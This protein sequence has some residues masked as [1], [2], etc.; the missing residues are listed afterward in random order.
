M[1][2]RGGKQATGLF[3]ESLTNPHIILLIL[4]RHLLG[5][6][7]PAR[8]RLRLRSLLLL[9]LLLHL[10][11][12]RRDTTARPPMMAQLAPPLQTQ[13]PGT[14]TS[15]TTLKEILAPPGT[16]AG[17]ARVRAGD[18]GARAARA[19]VH[20]VVDDVVVEP[21]RTGRG[22]GVADQGAEDGDR[23]RHDGDCALG[24]GEDDELGGRLGEV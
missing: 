13:Q 20:R 9:L 17:H 5:S 24:A 19:G 6:Q 4:N 3:L 11:R 8:R 22:P 15:R 16:G 2:G 12:Q 1:K 10:L 14:T 18:D 7:Y 23:G 21:G